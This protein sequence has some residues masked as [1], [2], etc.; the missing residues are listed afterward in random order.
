MLI[1]VKLFFKNNS[2]NILPKNK[3]EELIKNIWNLFSKYEW[4]DDLLQDVGPNTPMNFTVKCKYPIDIDKYPTRYDSSF[5]KYTWDGRKELSVDEACEKFI[6]KYKQ[7]NWFDSAYVKYNMINVVLKMR[8]N[9][10]LDLYEN[11]PIRYSY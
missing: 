5:I 6:Q 1:S 8:K 10:L 9:K 2:I 11:H 4:F 7:E 3:H